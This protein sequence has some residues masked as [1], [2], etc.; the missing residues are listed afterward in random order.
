MLGTVLVTITPATMEVVEV[1]TYVAVTCLIMKVTSIY[2]FAIGSIAINAR[3]IEL[4]V[5][6][7]GQFVYFVLKERLLLFW[8]QLKL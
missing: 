6:H 7:L 5:N 4:C 1:K 3:I 2:L 8:I